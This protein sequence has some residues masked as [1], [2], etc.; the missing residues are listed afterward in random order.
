[1][2]GMAHAPAVQPEVPTSAPLI[3]R[4]WGRVR[5]SFQRAWHE[6][7]AFSSA[8]WPGAAIASVAVGLLL[9]FYMGFDLHTGLGRIADLSLSTLLGALM[10]ALAGLLV[11][12]VATILRAWPRLFSAAFI[13]G[14]LLFCASPF[15]PETGVR[16]W[17][18]MGLPVILIGTGIAVLTRHARPVKRAYKVVAACVLVIGVAG[19]TTLLLWLASP[20]ADPNVADQQPM[21]VTEPQLQAA[22]PA[23]AGPYKVATMFYGSGTDRRRAEYGK[24]VA[25]KTTPVN[26]K[27]LLKNYKGFRARLR[28]WYWGFGIDALPLNGR[29]WYP[30]GDGPFPLVLIVHGNHEMTE[31]SD[32]GYAY[33]G[34]LLASRGFITVSVDENFMNGS[35]MGGIDKENGVRGWILLQHL[36]V[37]RGWNEAKDNPFFHKVDMNNIAL[38]GHS[39]GG[40]AIAHAAAFNRLKYFPEDAKVKFDFNFAIKTL[41]AIAPLDGQYQAVSEPTPLEN[42]NYLVLQGSHDSDV[43]FFA[44]YRP[45]RR[46]KFTDGQYRM[47]AAIYVYRANHGQFNTVWGSY[48]MGLPL[49]R[50]ILQKPLLPGDEQ[51][52]VAKTYITGFLEATLHGKQQYVPMFRDHRV[53]ASWLPKTIYFNSFEDSRYQVVS[54]F[55]K[56]IDVAATALPGGTIEGENLATWR[57]KEL[58]GRGGNWS[59]KKKAVL[60]GWQTAKPNQDGKPQEKKTATY[61]IVLPDGLAREWHLDQSAALAFSVADTDEKPEEQDDTKAEAK[62]EKAKSEKKTPVD[63][64]L[65]LADSAGNSARLPLSEFLPLQPILKVQFTK[66]SY[67]DQTAYKTATEPVFQT[68]ELSLGGFVRANPKLDLSKLKTIRFC[69]DRTESGVIAIDEIGF[70]WPK[71]PASTQTAQSLRASR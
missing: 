30:Q 49:K 42:V 35:W 26:A 70:A 28:K 64:T 37:W 66:W 41:I 61:A 25:L 52:R 65:E 43:S 47:K 22:N 59:F 19:L 55:E 46:V 13:G 2:D 45:F 60:L 67:L 1:M 6:T 3:K 5:S 57:H 63:F 18:G 62:Q 53:I 69:F 12:L 54:D 48:D 27:P 33:L 21:A 38:I 31:Y 36:A 58:A 68:F 10:I 16:V 4:V 7:A 8:A 71:P 29:V 15:G 14:I 50:L 32:P 40:E 9:M 17:A 39:R 11:M 20:G 44:G 56:T 51:R 23:E 24:Q 34:E